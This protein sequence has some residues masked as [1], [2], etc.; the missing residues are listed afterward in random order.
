MSALSRRALLT[1]AAGGAAY[2]ARPGF[3][4][5]PRL[6]RLIEQARAFGAI[7]ERMAFL[8]RALLGAGYIV[9]PLGG[10]PYRHERLVT[11]EDGYDCVTFCE[12][13]L[14][15]ARA[16]T[17]DE[18]A[19]ELRKIRYR[20]GEVDWFA[21][22]HYFADWMSNN[23]AN[24]ICQTLALP[25]AVHVRK[26]LNS[27]P[28]LPVATVDFIA[29]PTARVFAH[30]DLLAEGDIVAFVSQRAGLDVFHSGM[31]VR[32]AGGLLLRHASKSQGRV[33]DQPLARFCAFNG[34]RAITV[35][36]PQ[37]TIAGD[38]IV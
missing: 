27:M 8:S 33:L 2:L 9:D 38:V 22:N 3:A 11:R 17:P 1:A 30:A 10:G 24:G 29:N 5:E 25:G 32:G 18:F 4:L 19:P 6:P 15:A 12:T 16:R 36:R 26:I 7:G 34:V 20:N 13:V 31:I 35:S 28:S 37:E 14:A 23:A 21:R